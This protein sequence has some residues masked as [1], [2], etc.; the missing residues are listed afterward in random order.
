MSKEEFIDDIMYW[1]G[2]LPEIRDIGESYIMFEEPGEE[3][4]CIMVTSDLGDELPDSLDA[5]VC[6]DVF[7]GDDLYDE[8]QP[9]KRYDSL[10]EYL[11]TL[12]H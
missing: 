1:H 6:V 9:T 8:L 3:P 5:P 7:V 2:F 12:I 10:R 4:Y 11:D